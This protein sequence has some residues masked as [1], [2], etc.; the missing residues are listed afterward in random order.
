[1]VFTLPVLNT[2]YLHLLADANDTVSRINWNSMKKRDEKIV[3]EAER[4]HSSIVM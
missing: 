4:C 2:P 1:M 3:V